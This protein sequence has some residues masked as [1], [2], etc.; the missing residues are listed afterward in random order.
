MKLET[1]FSCAE[2]GDVITNPVC[3][4]CLATQMRIMVGEKDPELAREIESVS[5]SGRSRCM[6]CGKKM[7]LCA[8]CFSRDIY[9]FLEEKNPKIALEFLG[10]FDF[11]VREC[12]V[13]N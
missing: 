7:G 9:F 6:H 10:C 2:C 1:E 5:I 12:V 4:D 3:S 8:H 11:G 13:K